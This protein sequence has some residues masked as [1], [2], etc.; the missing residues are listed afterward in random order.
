MT[1]PRTAA[2]AVGS[3]ASWSPSRGHPYL[4]A[5]WP[6]GHVLG[7]EHTFVHQAR[8]LLT[9]IGG[10][11]DP[12]PSFADGLQVQRVLAAVA[13][14][15]AKD[16]QWAPVAT[17]HLTTRALTPST[18]KPPGT[19][20]PIIM[21]RP[22]TLFTGQWADLPLEEVCRPSA[23]DW[24]YDGLELACWGDHFEVDWALAEDGYLAG[25]THALLAKYE[26]NCWAILQPPGRAGGLRPPHRPA[27]PGHPARP[28]LGRRRAGRRPA[29][30]R[31]RT[32]RHRPGPR[33]RS[34]VQTVVGFTGSSIWYTVAMFPPVPP[35]M[36]EQGYADFARRWNPILDVFDREWRPVLRTRCIPARSPTT[37]GPPRQALDAVGNLGPR[38]G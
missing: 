15:A 26:L 24:G 33:P 36:I 32:G 25:P 7:W 13:D 16:S 11:D 14:S 6:P 2:T 4:S 17:G 20:E 31:R 29:A 30:G 28:D 10:D 1:G 8:D 12:E 19:K 27:A 38:S 18:K 37:S 23:R 22:V 21:S 34:G 3:A 9:D 35:E 5:W